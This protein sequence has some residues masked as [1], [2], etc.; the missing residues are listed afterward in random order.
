MQLLES[1][2]RTMLRF[3]CN[4]RPCELSAVSNM[5]STE[6]SQ[7][8]T[9]TQR[10][11]EAEQNKNKNKNKTRPQHDDQFIYPA[12]TALTH[13]YETYCLMLPFT[14]RVVPTTSTI[15]DAHTLMSPATKS[16]ISS[17]GPF[18]PTPPLSPPFPC[19]PPASNNGARSSSQ[20]TR[21]PPPA[22]C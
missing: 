6:R 20:G 15:F 5:T 18:T 10:K 9:Q 11:L 2:R 22:P 4:E 12:P 3:L 14:T 1:N 8:K 21:A 16:S 13:Y 7:K 17:L 19:R